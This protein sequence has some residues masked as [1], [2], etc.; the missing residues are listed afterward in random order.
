MNK[1]R[2]I[3]NSECYYELNMLKLLFKIN[4]LT[5]EYKCVV[6]IVLKESENIL[7]TA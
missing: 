1:S 7:L 2:A 6:K 5:E 4:L 3:K